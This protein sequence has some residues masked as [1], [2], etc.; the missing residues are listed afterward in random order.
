MNDGCC[1]YNME[2]SDPDIIMPVTKDVTYPKKNKILPD[3][4]DGA[5][6]CLFVF[7]YKQVAPTVLA[8]RGWN[9]A[10]HVSDSL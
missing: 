4:S 9:N 6:S 7:Y 8:L 1:W 5:I 2:V 10:C 3:R